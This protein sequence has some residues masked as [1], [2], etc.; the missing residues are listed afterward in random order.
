MIEAIEKLVAE[1]DLTQQMLGPIDV[2][3]QYSWRIVLKGDGE[4]LFPLLSSL[5]RLTGVHIEADPLYV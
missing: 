5:Y 1:K 3:G 2:K 4:A